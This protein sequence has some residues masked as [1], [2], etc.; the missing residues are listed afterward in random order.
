MNSNR[1]QKLTLL[2]VSTLT[3]MAGATISP[4]LP[5][6][7][8]AFSGVA[9]ADVWVRLVLTLPA[10]FIVLGAPLAG[11][12]TDRLG[13]KPLLVAATILYGLAGAS[14]FVLESLW[15]ILAGRALLGLAVG[16]IMT[17]VTTLISDYFEGKERANVLGL[18]GTF[19]NLGG[20]L[21]LTLGGVLADLE[22]RLPFLIYLFAF[23]LLPLVLYSLDEPEQVENDDEAIGLAQLPWGLLS[24][25]YS[26][27]LVF[28]TIFYTIPVQLPFYLTNSFGASGTLT[29]LA[30]ATASLFGAVSST[31]YS[32]ISDRLSYVA[33]LSLLF[34]LMSVG[35][36]FIGL[37]TS[38][39]FVMVGLAVA[40]LG[41]GLVLPN[42]NRWTS[43]SASAKLRGRALSGVT[44]ATFL[45]QFLSPLATQ[46]L[47]NATG[48]ATMYLALSGVLLALAVVFGL[49]RLP[50]RRV[51][52]RAAR[53]PKR[54][55]R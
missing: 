39:V 51:A 6:M 44:T 35:Y 16:G 41:L 9:N 2:L 43:E 54:Q 27:G 14:G 34:T 28:M 20:I 21:F 12:I 42:L 10:L 1:W 26:A 38:V 52:E 47:A 32:R 31:L 48:L 55:L 4:S 45:G 7:R 17:S 3:I 46:P 50:I 8:E 19:M 40:G 29:G 36:A 53:R 33:I 30:V 11:L 23:V 22:W 13:R 18:Q 5:A 25:I 37:A 24:I 49:L 15:A